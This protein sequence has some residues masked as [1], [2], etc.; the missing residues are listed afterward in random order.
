MF[1][2]VSGKFCRKY[3]KTGILFILLSLMGGYLITNLDYFGSSAHPG[4]GYRLQHNNETAPEPTAR[5]GFI[6]TTVKHSY[7]N[8]HP[9]NT[10]IYYLARK[11]KYEQYFE[12][13]F[14]LFVRE[15]E[16][17]LELQIA[18]PP[19]L[20][21]ESSALGVSLYNFSLRDTLAY[22]TVNTPSDCQRS[23]FDDHY[24][25]Q[26]N[27]PTESMALPLAMSDYGR[28]YCFKIRLNV[29]K[30]GL[31]FKPYKIFAV[32][33]QIQTMGVNNSVNHNINNSMGFSQSIMQ[34]TYYDYTLNRLNGNLQNDARDAYYSHINNYFNLYTY[35][36][37][38][39]L[40]LRI[41][42]PTGIAMPNRDVKYFELEKI[43]YTTVQE[44]GD[45][46]RAIFEQDVRQIDD[47]PTATPAA[48]SLTPA[49]ADHGLYY[50]LKIGLEGEKAWA[51]NLHPYK[52]FF[53]PQRITSSTATTDNSAWSITPAS[54]TA[55]YRL[56]TSN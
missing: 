8:H 51:S 28:Y 9:T 32:D 43:E 21:T 49:A 17:H 23:L 26:V 37:T 18:V 31:D 29:D 40:D 54:S 45:C 38:N 3:F 7:S 33:R 15:R 35:Q 11:A 1:L 42:K 5:V 25:Y 2:Q 53:V 4:S 48:I 20:R 30:P 47:T 10:N 19:Q 55:R 24:S 34:S 16:N 12:T 36:T 50:C 52:I 14:Q 56:R 44:R 22:N 41:Y 6:P 13:H 46:D 39:R 27:N